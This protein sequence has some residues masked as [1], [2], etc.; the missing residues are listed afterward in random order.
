[1]CN[2]C[3]MCVFTIHVTEEKSTV[4]IVFYDKYNSFTMK[5]LHIIFPACHR[6][7]SSVYRTVKLTYTVCTLMCLC[8]CLC[9]HMYLCVREFICICVHVF[10]CMCA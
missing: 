6:L 10:V 7:M 2:A 1:M 5:Y 3:V 9:V 8:V 4:S